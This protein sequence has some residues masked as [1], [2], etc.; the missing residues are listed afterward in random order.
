MRIII[1][2]LLGIV[3][4]LSGLFYERSNINTTSYWVWAGINDSDVPVS[5]VYYI[6]QGIIKID[7]RQNQYTRKGLYP[8][9]LKSQSI[10]LVYRLEGE[11][12]TSK[13][14]VD[15]FLMHAAQWEKHDLKV[16]G[17]QLDFDSATSKLLSY[18]EFLQNLKMQL[19]NKYLI[20]ITGLADWLIY[21]DRSIL[22]T[23]KNNVDEIIFQLYQGRNHFRDIHRYISALRNLNI[24]FKVGLLINE[25]HQEYLTLL[26]DNRFFNGVVYFVQK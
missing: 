25:P 19:P 12:P 10:F 2:F 15:L 18:N 24:D 3:F 6:Y 26:K 5:D 8:S 16:K 9:R 11:L 22:G 4:L 20:S 7:S 17:I 23:I 21:G 13:D 14:L 1:F